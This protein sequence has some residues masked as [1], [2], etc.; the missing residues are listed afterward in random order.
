VVTLPELDRLRAAIDAVD[1]KILMLIGER[2]KLVLGVGEIKRKHGLAVYDPKR[3][4]EVLEQLVH[5]ATDPLDAETIRRVFECLIAES[6]RIE[7]S[8]VAELESDEP[9][10]KTGK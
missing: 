4:T 9:D 5:Q 10:P 7:Q 6:R 3:E 1:K 8:H 2:V